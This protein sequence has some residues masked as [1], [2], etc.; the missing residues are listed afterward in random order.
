LDAFSKDYVPFHLMT[1]EF[2]QILNDKLAK[3]N[4]V[5]VSNQIGSLGE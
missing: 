3:P 4:G 5:I 1:L 2:F